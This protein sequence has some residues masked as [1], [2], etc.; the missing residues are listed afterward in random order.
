MTDYRRQET[1]R[2]LNLNTIGYELADGIATVTLSRPDRLNAFTTEMVDEF[3]AVI[4]HTDADDDVRAVI[5]TG[6]GGAFSAGADFEDLGA[7]VLTPMGDD[8]EPDIGGL[9]TLRLFRSLKPTIAAVNGPA[10]G[11]GATVQL[12]MDVRIASEKAKF[13]FVFARRG[14]VPEAA[15]SWFL[16]RIVGIATALRWC[17]GGRMVDALEAR[18]KLLVSEVVSA[19]DLMPTARRIASE[20]IDGVAPVSVAMTRRMLWSMLAAGHPMDGHVLDSQAIACRTRSADKDE[21]IASFLE[22]RPARFPDRVSDG[23]PPIFPPIPPFGR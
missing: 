8:L 17:M 2:V 1:S 9:M 18:E 19:K 12:A 15:S 14:I 11:V 20:F 4:D 6:A 23:L 5:F 13:G 10:V 22:K 7:E 21:G 16:P 3:L